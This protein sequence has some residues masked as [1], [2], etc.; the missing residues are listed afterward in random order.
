V[1]KGDVMGEE[2][3]ERAVESMSRKGSEA[4]ASR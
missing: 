2:I 4:G 3:G 1:R